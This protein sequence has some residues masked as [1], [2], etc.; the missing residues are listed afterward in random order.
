MLEN[1]LYTSREAAR[2]LELSV[3]TVKYHVYKSGLLQ[4]HLIGKT[5]VFTK[6]ELDV[7]RA[8]DYKPGWKRGRKRT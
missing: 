5:R 2:Y 3:S 4:G 1:V 6:D 8:A 7:F